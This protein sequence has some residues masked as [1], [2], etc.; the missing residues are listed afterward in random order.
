M[1][2]DE[3]RQRRIWQQ[4]F[5]GGPKIMKP[6]EQQFENEALKKQTNPGNKTVNRGGRQAVKFRKGGKVSCRE[7]GK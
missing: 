7:Y 4:A 1:S 3:D 2:D 5:K 6:D